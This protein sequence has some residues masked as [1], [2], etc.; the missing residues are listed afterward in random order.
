MFVALGTAKPKWNI[1]STVVSYVKIKGFGE[2]QPGNPNLDSNT[3]YCSHM[4]VIGYRVL[5][6]GC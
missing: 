3:P 2:P 4:I 1:D 5:G 6:L